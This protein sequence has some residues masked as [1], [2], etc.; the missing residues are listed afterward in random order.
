MVHPGL[1]P[2][3]QP[4]GIN[5]FVAGPTGVG[6]E[7]VFREALCSPITCRMTVISVFTNQ[8]V[9]VVQF[10]LIPSVAF[11]GVEYFEKA[12]GSCGLLG[13][14]Q[15]FVFFLKAMVFHLYNSYP[16]EGTAE[17]LSSNVTNAL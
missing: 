14:C 16:E 17:H 1:H 9:S 15:G 4:P 5:P 12:A 2:W 3:N 13:G 6:W 7:G 11:Q 10:E 8:L